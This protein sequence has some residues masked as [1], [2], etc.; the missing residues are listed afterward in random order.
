MPKNFSKAQNIR[1]TDS[2]SNWQILKDVS[3]NFIGSL[4]SN[5][6]AYGLGLMLLDQTGLAISFGVGMVITPIVGLLFLIP[7]GSLTDRYPHKKILN[8]SIISRLLAL[9][10]FAFFIDRF[11][12]RYKLIPVIIFLI[13]NA[14]SVNFSNTSYSAAVH[15]LVNENKIQKLGSLTQGSISLSQILA[16]AIG[17][18]LY[19]IVGF[20]T[21][22]YFEILA[23]SLTF[24]ILQTMHFHYDNSSVTT[25]AKTSFEDF[26]IGLNYVNRRK[27]IKFVIIMAVMI[28]FIFTALNLGIP[29][30]IKNQ[31]HLGNSPV[32]YLQSGIAVGMLGGSI[33]MLLLP[34]KKWFVQKLLLPLLSFGLEFVLLGIVFQRRLSLWQVN[35]WGT[36]IMALIGLTLAVLNIT[37]QVRLQKTVPTNILGRV[38]ALLTTANTSVMPLGTLFYTFFFQNN[39][40]GGQIFIVNGVIMFVYT[41]FLTPTLLKNIKLDDK[42]AE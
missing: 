24:L 3:S 20:D 32:G 5:M 36:V 19:S 4:S 22:I 27:L 7:I 2:E 37:V 13:I 38:M 10:I 26:K 28:N 33:L 31:L 42:Y 21:F 39:F 16:P 15:E 18:S 11:Q 14:I 35:I 25:Q 17:V 30:V 8:Y 12:G 23:A 6:F 9:L 1:I 34:D 29:Y 41:V 40:N